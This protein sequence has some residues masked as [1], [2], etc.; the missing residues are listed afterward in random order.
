MTRVHLAAAVAAFAALTGLAGAPVAQAASATSPIRNPPLGTCLDPSV[1]PDPYDTLAG[2]PCSGSAAQSFSF[3]AL[4]G[5]PAHTY[6]IINQVDGLC[7]DQYRFGVEQESC[8]TG[9]SRPSNVS[10]T[11][12]LDGT[13]A[14]KYQIFVTPTVGT[15]SPRCLQVNPQASGQPGPLF[16]LSACS[17]SRAQLFTLTGGL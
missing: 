13:S 6:E 9:S 10:W 4:P 15:S 11:L 8:T 3:D 14:R 16:V 7:L 17:S 2:A 1:S 12:Q 5:G